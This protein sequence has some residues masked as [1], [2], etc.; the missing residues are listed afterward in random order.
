M[1]SYREELKRIVSNTYLLDPKYNRSVK[2]AEDLADKLIDSVVAQ[3]QKEAIEHLR[4][5]VKPAGDYIDTAPVIHA[6]HLDEHINGL[7]LQSTTEEEQ[8]DDPQ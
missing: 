6:G 2:E 8:Q 5:E 3:K 7:S 4:R 1:S